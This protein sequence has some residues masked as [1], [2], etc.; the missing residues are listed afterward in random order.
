MLIETN[1]SEVFRHKSALVLIAANLLPLLGIF[2]FGWSAGEILLLYWSE[3]AIIGFYTILKILLAGLSSDT[4][5][6]LR[7]VLMPVKLFMMGFFVVHFG[8][9]MLGHLVFVIFL[10]S[11]SSSTSIIL[12]EDALK[13]ALALWPAVVFLFLSHGYSFFYNYIA[14]GECKTANIGELM[15]APYRRIIVMHVVIIIGAFFIFALRLPYIPALL[16]ILI[17]TTMDLRAHLAERRRFVRKKAQA[18]LKTSP[19]KKKS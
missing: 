13:L 17:K 8:G 15:F 16:L 5:L 4:P 12:I 2:L 1:F 10:L 11:Y 3:S 9:F 14:R 18:S 6:A 7:L 19:K